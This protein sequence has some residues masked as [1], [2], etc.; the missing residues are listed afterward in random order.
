LQLQIEQCYFPCSVTVMESPTATTT[1]SAASSDDTDDT[2]TAVTPKEMPFLLGLD[3]MKRHLC[4]LDLRRGCLRFTISAPPA[5]AADADAASQQ[6]GGH[7]M[8][9]PFLHE[10][11]LL[12]AQGGTKRVVVPADKE[13]D[14]KMDE[15]DDDDDVTAPT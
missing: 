13:E 14:H 7:F 9:A 5:D 4:C 15:D 11:D 6:D 10:K 2:K 8:D 12:P 3:M 1:T